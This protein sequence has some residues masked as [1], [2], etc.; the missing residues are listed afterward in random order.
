MHPVLLIDDDEGLGDVLGEYVAGFSIRLEQALTPQAGL[1][2]LAS[3][4]FEAVILDVMLPGM[5][6]FDVLR[7]LRRDSDVPVVMLSARGDVTDR[8][9]G[10]EIGAD[11]YLPKPFEPRELVARVLA[12]LRRPARE[13]AHDGPGPVRRFERLAIDPLA[14]EA[15]LDGGAAGLTTKEFDLLLLLSASPGRAFS[16]D[17]IL[18]ALTG[19]E[20]EL[21]T[22]SV[23]ILVSRL[24]AKLRPLEPIRTLHGA[25]Y[26]FAALPVA[27]APDAP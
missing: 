20:H 1:E 25:G 9:V 21:F 13:G 19:T 4:R 2:A 17:E 10:L 11:D 14:R 23:D 3:N 15:F 6:G 7:R 22:R 16:R 18:A 24:R 27:G 8:I 12:N 5:T 26:A